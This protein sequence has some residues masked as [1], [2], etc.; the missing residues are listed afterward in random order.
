MDLPATPASTPDTA[1][2]HDVY[3]AMAPASLQRPGARAIYHVADPD[4]AFTVA[5]IMG[6]HITLEGVPSVGKTTFL[7]SLGAAVEHYGG[8]ANVHEEN[9]DTDMQHEFFRDPAKNAFWFQMF[10]LR[11]R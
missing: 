5:T 2:F 6:K 9:P 4:Y 11:G 1:Y 7:H 8:S 3:R 10:K